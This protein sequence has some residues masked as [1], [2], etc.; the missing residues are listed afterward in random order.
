MVI[1]AP[2]SAIP[3]NVTTKS[4]PTAS[5]SI[6][7]A[8][9]PTV[10]I[11]TPNLQ[12]QQVPPRPPPINRHYSKKPFVQR[13]ANRVK[14]FCCCIC[15]PAYKC[16]LIT[17]TFELILGCYF[18]FDALN[19]VVK[20]YWQLK[21]IIIFLFLTGW[22]V[23][24]GTAFGTL[25]AAQ[26]KKT[27]HCV[28]PRLVL[29]GGILITCGVFFLLVMLYFNGSSKTMNNIFL[30]IMEFF[31]QQNFTPEERKDLHGELHQLAYGF[32]AL[33]FI[34]T[35]YTLFGFLAT[36]KFYKDLLREYRNFHPVAQ[37][38]PSAPPLQPA[39]NPSYNKE[40]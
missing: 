26:R 21:D 20:N 24:A 37:G 34:F 38:E 35:C 39:F 8:Q 14:M 13:A 16:A 32:T 18:W 17:A 15:C 40:V 19:D 23:A 11:L 25:I 6:D 33:L 22:L 9:N 10:I 1:Q 36:R 28:W 30:D 12:H 27:P 5:L 4:V 31:M 3:L 2:P 29:L 7:S